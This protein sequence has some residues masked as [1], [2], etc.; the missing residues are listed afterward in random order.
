MAIPNEELSDLKSLNE[1]RKIFTHY[2]PAGWSIG[3]AGLPRILATT[4]RLVRSL[5]K[6]PSITYRMPIALTR[7]MDRALSAIE[8]ELAKLA[9]LKSYYGGPSE[10][11]EG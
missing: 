6:H 7:R 3:L 9:E 11:A 5:A 2:D 10:A 4:I 8:P 1:L